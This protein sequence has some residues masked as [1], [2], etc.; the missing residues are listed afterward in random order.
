MNYTAWEKEE[1]ALDLD[2]ALQK[3]AQSKETL[4][5]ISGSD[6]FIFST[7]NIV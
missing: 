1:I 3:F 5:F 6:V 7:A 2:H 4:D